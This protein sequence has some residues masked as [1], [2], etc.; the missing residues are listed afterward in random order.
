MK[1]ICIALAAA[2][3]AANVHAA[4]TLNEAE[5]SATDGAWTLAVAADEIDGVTGLKVTS[6]SMGESSDL[7]L[8]TFETD[9]GKKIIRFNKL[10]QWGNPAVTSVDAPTVLRV[11]DCCFQGVTSLTSAQFPA[12]TYL[13]NDCFNACGNLESVSFSEDITYIGGSCFYQAKKI[14]IANPNWPQLE[15]L[16]GNAFT[17]GPV[18]TGDVKVPSLLAVSSALSGQT[19]IKSLYAPM[20]TTFS[21]AAFGNT[22]G[23]TNITIKGSAT[24]LANAKNNFAWCGNSP[25]VFYWLG[26]EAPTTM[27]V[28]AIYSENLK[29]FR[30]YVNADATATV[31]GWK[32]YCGATAEQIASDP[33]YAYYQKIDGYD[34]IKD[35]LIGFLG[36]AKLGSYD[37]VSVSSLNS[38]GPCWIVNLAEVEEEETYHAAVT[39]PERAKVERVVANGFIVQPDAEGKYEMLSSAS[40]DITYR[41]DAGYQFEGRLSVYTKTGVPAAKEIGPETCDKVIAPVTYRTLTLSAAE[42]AAANIASVTLTMGEPYLCATNG[43]AIAYSVYDGVAFTLTYAATRK[44]RFEG[45]ARTSVAE[46]AEGITADTVIAASDLPT[47]SELICRWTYDGSTI[48]DGNW[49]FAVE[50]DTVDGVTGLRLRTHKDGDGE[51]DLTKFQ[52]ESGSQ[53]DVVS[54]INWAVFPAGTTRIVAPGII[55]FDASCGSRCDVGEIIATNAVYF[56]Y[57]AFNDCKKLTNLVFSANVKSFGSSA[58]SGCTSLAALGTTDWPQ[59]T[60]LG[61]SA[62]W[63]TSI[64]GDLKM[65][66]VTD[67]QVAFGYTR[68]TSLYAPKC[69]IL[70]YQALLDCKAL[71]NLVIKGSADCFT[72]A[73]AHQAMSGVGEVA[74]MSYLGEVAP[75]Y[76]FQASI[77]SAVT[78][79]PM[80]LYVNLRGATGRADWEKLCTATAAD[81]KT[82]ATYA[83]VKKIPDYR[84]VRKAIVGFIGDVETK[85]GEFVRVKAQAANREFT[86]S[87]NG[88]CWVIDADYKDPG[89]AVLVR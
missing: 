48:A 31:Q 28:K 38:N 20:A 55:R 2:F 44:Y 81:I 49:S 75:S 26:N 5:T 25:G 33:A 84:K 22:G 66:E 14:S 6:V 68:I 11:E 87:G 71:T 62:F 24:A 53:Y 73:R 76:L 23:Y 1:Q 56:G 43:D 13:G 64:V 45:G 36:T 42:L 17:G 63:N 8:S 61:T 65:P 4:W 40:V 52:E 35:R 34:E 60:T 39:A 77:C 12:A 19:G 9:T 29:L 16:G 57:A 86:E 88:P 78:N 18:I 51:L 10:F 46:F 47:T 89:F 50:R 32:S 37:K 21:G 74:T 72:T 15:T 27:P 79:A 80:K 3:L 85:S 7:D 67:I 58:F 82:N 83:A 70:D 69:E 41:A 59:L 54:T 30:L